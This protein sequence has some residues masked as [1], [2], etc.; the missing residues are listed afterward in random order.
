MFETESNSELETKFGPQ[1][2][3]I[4]VLL[5]RLS[6]L[7]P[8]EFIQIAARDVSK[9]AVRDAAWGAAWDAA[10]D[11]SKA[12]VRDAA[13]GAAWD[14]AWDAA[15]GAVSGAAD[16][17][18]WDVAWGAVRDSVSGAAW[19]VVWGATALSVY[20]LIG[21]HGFTQEHYDLLTG[22]LESVIGPLH[23][24]NAALEEES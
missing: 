20:D 1:W 14:A 21:Q 16:G 17:A 10:L 12:A 2:Q 4:V 9:A 13:W 5:D 19:A 24:L 18:T 11:V 22:P 23:T 6:V 15:W 7:T 8:T 3:Q